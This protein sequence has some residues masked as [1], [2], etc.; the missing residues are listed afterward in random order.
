[1]LSETHFSPQGSSTDIKRGA[2]NSL[3]MCRV[4]H[5]KYTHTHTHISSHQASEQNS[6]AGIYCHGDE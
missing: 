6:A 3:V 4:S 1:V 5:T 2:D